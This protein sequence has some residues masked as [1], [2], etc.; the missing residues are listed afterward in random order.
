MTNEFGSAGC[1]LS[2]SVTI[3]NHVLLFAEDFGV[4]IFHYR[5]ILKCRFYTTE[6]FEVPIFHYGRL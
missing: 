5:K 2:R 1:P 6:D 3:R 4:P